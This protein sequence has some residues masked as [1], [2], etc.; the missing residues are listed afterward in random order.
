VNPNLAAV[1]FIVFTDVKSMA[2]LLS[3][4]RKAIG[5]IYFITNDTVLSTIFLRSPLIFDKGRQFGQ[6][7]IY[8]YA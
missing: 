5:V 4:N 7:M 3:Y 8:P 2:A 1:S 6:N